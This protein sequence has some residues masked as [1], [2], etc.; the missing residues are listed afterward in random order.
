M[1]AAFTFPEGYSCSTAA[2]SFVASLLQLKAQD[3]LTAEEA[4][5]HRWLS[6]DAPPSPGALL[7]S[8]QRPVKTLL[9]EFNAQR[10]LG[11]MIRGAHRRLS[12]DKEPPAQLP[13]RL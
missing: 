5:A 2:Q 10:M 6:R 7:S 12:A 1:K 9:S 13:P 3:R 4:L 11:R 8:S